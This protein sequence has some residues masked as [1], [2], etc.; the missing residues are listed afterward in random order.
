[1]GAY[2]LLT[3][4]RAG[5]LPE[6]PLP[7]QCCPSRRGTGAPRSPRRGEGGP[8]S[9]P[10][11]RRRCWR[12]GLATTQTLGPLLDGCA[13]RR[14]HQGMAPYYHYKRRTDLEVQL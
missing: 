3:V 5:P 14:W 13:W 4:G 2:A 9:V 10:E 11:M 6:S 1:M 7:P 12:L 8:L